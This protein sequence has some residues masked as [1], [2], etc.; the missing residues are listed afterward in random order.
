[1]WHGEDFKTGESIPNLVEGGMHKG[2]CFLGGP[3]IVVVTRDLAG[4][5]SH[6]QFI[7]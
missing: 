1:M 6:K 5:I 4:N 7:C 3:F 2:I